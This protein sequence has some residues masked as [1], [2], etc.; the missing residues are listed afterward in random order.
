MC[1]LE[2][3]DFWISAWLPL[4]NIQTPTLAFFTHCGFLPLIAGLPFSHKSEVSQIAALTIF[5]ALVASSST[6]F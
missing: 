1:L 2:I 3:L 6:E 4:L 5:G